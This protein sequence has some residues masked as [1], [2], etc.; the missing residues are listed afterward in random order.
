[1]VSKMY[2]LYDKENDSYLKN[3]KDDVD[4]INEAKIFHSIEQLKRFKRVHS[5][6]RHESVEVDLKVT[7]V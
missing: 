6:F 4:D 7:R 2:V 5:F 1:M 3:L